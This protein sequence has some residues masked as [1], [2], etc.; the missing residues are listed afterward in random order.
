LKLQPEEFLS[1]R[2]VSYYAH[3]ATKKELSSW[4]LKLQTAGIRTRVI[5]SS[6]RDLDFLP[7]GCDKGRATA[8]L[9]K[10]WGYTSL[11]VIAS[12][13]TGNDSAFFEQGFLGTIVGNALP[14]LKALESPMIYHAQAGFAAGVQEGLEYWLV[15]AKQLSDVAQ[16]P[17]GVLSS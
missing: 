12:G 14:E 16:F 5:Y 3:Q 9:A 10:H 11:Q 6:Q 1:P 17:A 8:F 7:A 13:D 2:K 15:Q 4:K